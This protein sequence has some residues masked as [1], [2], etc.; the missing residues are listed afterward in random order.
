[1]FV[2]LHSDECVRLTGWRL[3][4]SMCGMSITI[5]LPP[6]LDRDVKGIPDVEKRVIEFLRDQADYE[7]WRR[8]RYSD[9]AF[10]ILEESKAEAE[11]L[12]ASGKSREELFE[13]FMVL[14]ERITRQI[15][16]KS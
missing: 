10:Q 3:C 8:A 16:E 1:M 12:R 6:D 11:Q 13:E 5:E 9:E 14:H 2:C 4:G 7:K 15:A